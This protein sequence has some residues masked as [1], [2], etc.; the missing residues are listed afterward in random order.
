LE[1][2]QHFLWLRQQ[3]TSELIGPVDRL[4][5]VNDILNLFK[6]ALGLLGSSLL[7]LDMGVTAIAT[8]QLPKQKEELEVPLVCDV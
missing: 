1:F 8:H 4:K 6:F 2:S 5:N 3:G 7:E